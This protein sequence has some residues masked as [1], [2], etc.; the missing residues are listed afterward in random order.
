MDDK[1]SKILDKALESS[2][3]P[4]HHIPG[5]EWS[6]CGHLVSDILDSPAL[7]DRLY[8]LFYPATVTPTKI[9]TL[10]IE[11]IRSR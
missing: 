3:L 6:I 7:Q 1:F 4:M 9:R 2:R 8:E 10:T 11:D 5:S